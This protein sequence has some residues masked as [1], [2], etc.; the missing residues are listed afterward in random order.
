M[1][2]DLDFHAA[3]TDVEFTQ[4]LCCWSAPEESAQSSVAAVT[5]QEEGFEVNAN[6]LFASAEAPKAIAESAIP[7]Q[8][9]STA[10]QQL[11]TIWRMFCKKPPPPKEYTM[12]RL[13]VTVY[14]SQLRPPSHI[15]PAVL[16]GDMAQQAFGL[17]NQLKRGQTNNRLMVQTGHMSSSDGKPLCCIAVMLQCHSLLMNK[18]QDHGPARTHRAE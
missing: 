14:S 2:P 11:N 8:T 12:G 7:A 18:Q 13:V 17:V 4:T 15:V 16:P 1:V 3:G 9:T 6:P 10:A 5:C